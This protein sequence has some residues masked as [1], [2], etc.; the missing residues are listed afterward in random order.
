MI[1]GAIFDVDGTLLDSMSIWGT[2]GE[3]YLRSLGCIPHENLTE[4][5]KCFS[6]YEAACY[7]RSEYGITLSVEE[8]LTGINQM[9]EQYYF[10]ETQAK[11]GVEAFLRTLQ[12]HGVKMCI[13]TSIDTYLIDASLERC[14]IRSYF[15]EIFTSNAVGHGKSEPHIYR[16][17]QASLGTPIEETYVFED[18]FYAAKAAAAVGF[19]I[20]G[21]YDPSETQ[22]AELKSLSEVYLQD[23]RDTASISA[24]L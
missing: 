9:I 24:L 2:V 12:E 15:S 13:A 8:I 19:P 7:Y 18:A 4:T 22:Q 6:L 10:T 16:A 3:D 17:A 21:V 23:F 20:I 11:P 5:F 14:G 1:R